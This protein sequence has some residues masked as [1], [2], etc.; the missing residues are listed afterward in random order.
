MT[1]KTMLAPNDDPL[2]NPAFFDLVQLPTMASPKLDGIRTNIRDGRVLSRTL[3]DLP[4][5]LLVGTFGSF[6]GLDGE[7][8]VGSPTDEDVYN[9]T[10]RVI[11]KKKEAR[12]IDDVTLY[13][14]DTN[15]DEYKDEPFHVRYARARDLVEAYS[16][17]QVKLVPHSLIGNLTDLEVFEKTQLDAGY[18]GIMGRSVDGTYKYG[19]ATMKQ[20][21]L[22]K[23]KRFTDVEVTVISL[24]EQMTNTN[25]K[26][27][28]ELGRS[29]RS[30]HKAG[31]VP[32][33]T[34]GGFIVDM[35]GLTLDVGC[36]I[37][38]HDER[39]EIWDAGQE[40]SEGR[41]FTMR[42]FGYGVKDKPRFPR[43]YGWRD[44]EYM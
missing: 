29:Q 36:G 44:M 28:N 34:L 11:M 27:T 20:G 26:T 12:S 16:H 31:M 3:K 22:F 14:F 15:E 41:T 8:I 43:Y 35:D 18:E 39:K 1:F 6:H 33:N 25:K 38:K 2:K 40:A 23:L 17:P 32:A 21:S 7:F 10:Q 13:V 5:T 24:V 37:L 30:S 9:N 42:F 4:N 19:R